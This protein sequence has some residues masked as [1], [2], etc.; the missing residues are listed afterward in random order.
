MSE[1]EKRRVSDHDA[2]VIAGVG[3]A[4]VKAGVTA[5]ALVGAGPGAAVGV[6]LAYELTG[7]IFESQRQRL[8]EFA[9]CF[10]K[11]TSELPADTQECIR[12][13]LKTD[14]GDR[15]FETAWRQ[16]AEAVDPDKLNLIATLVKNSLSSKDLQE[17]QIRWLLRL[18]DELDPVQI[19]ILQSHVEE[20]QVNEKFYQAHSVV[21]DDAKHPELER[22]PYP[23]YPT[24]PE[25]ES[26][27]I[28][29]QSEWKALVEEWQIERH[30]YEVAREK[31]ALFQSRVHHLAEMGLLGAK[32]KEDE[33]V[34][35][36][37]RF[38]DVLQTLTPLGAAL[39]K[40][41]DLAN[42]TH[43]GT[44]E[45]INPVVALQQAKAAVISYAQKEHELMERAI[46]QL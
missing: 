24:D 6:A 44:G 4:I 18:L 20:G 41:L 32:V 16:A 2:Q 28:R 12:E 8:V 15:I 42:D 35:D 39:L 37:I 31:H 5:V 22:Y 26:E 9:A 17:H 46:R 25:T 40:V 27:R 45:Q 1:I 36:S 10:A 3:G 29:R 19:L 11:R 13:R 38:G 23:Y 21:F 34:F 7:V 14:A 43:W 30:N 33:L